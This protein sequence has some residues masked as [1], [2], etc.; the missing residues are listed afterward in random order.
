MCAFTTL[1]PV[2][3]ALPPSDLIGCHPPSFSQHRGPSRILDYTTQCIYLMKY[4]LWVEG[5][6]PCHRHPI[7]LLKIINL[8]KIKVLGK[9]KIGYM[10]RINKR[11]KGRTAVILLS[12]NQCSG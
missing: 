4:E 6:T 3:V 5:A 7:H 9:V 10:P 12:W 8:G 11:F 2:S 1:K